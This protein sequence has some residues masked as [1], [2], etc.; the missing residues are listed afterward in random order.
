[1]ERLESLLVGC[2]VV[3]LVLTGFALGLVISDVVKPKAQAEEVQVKLVTLFEKSE[4]TSFLNNCPEFRATDSNCARLEEKA[5]EMEES[6]EDA[7]HSYYTGEELR[8]RDE[9][10]EERDKDELFRR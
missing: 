5:L 7:Y 4:W 8:L 2:L 1:M 10:E 9:A 3:A 6:L